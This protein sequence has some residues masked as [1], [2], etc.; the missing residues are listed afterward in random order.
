MR[1]PI[2]ANNAPMIL[3]LKVRT[4]SNVPM[5]IIVS[6]A[7]KNDQG[8]LAPIP[9]TNYTDRTGT[10]KGERTFYVRMPKTPELLVAQVFNAQVGDR[11]EGVDKTFQIVSKDILPIDTYP[12]TYKSGSDLVK[13]AI[14]FIQDFSERA[15]WQSAGPGAGS[16]YKSNCGRFRI[17]YLDVIRDRKTGKELATPARI[18]QDRG[19]IEVSKKHF[20]KYAVPYRVAIL[21]HEISHFYLNDN[22]QNEVEAD[23]NAL[24]MFLGLGYGYIDAENAFLNVFKGSPSDQNKERHQIL[25]NFIVDF[26]ERYNKYR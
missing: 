20:L 13:C 14:E 11:A 6:G 1:I 17:D 5:R 12:E 16:T 22:P 26:E 4:N 21:L 8:Q 9:N 23:L 15:G 24:K 2:S 7:F 3:A 19:I 25:H 10:V 18:S